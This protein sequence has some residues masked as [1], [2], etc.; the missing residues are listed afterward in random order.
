MNHK[1]S[2]QNKTLESLKSADQRQ[3][4]LEIEQLEDRIAPTMFSMVG[5][6]DY[7]VAIKYDA[8]LEQI[9]LNYTKIT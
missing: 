8:P 6:Y 4:N 2:S 1:Q 3:L 7:S 5:T 9:S